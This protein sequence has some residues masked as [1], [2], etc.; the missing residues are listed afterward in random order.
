MC[1]QKLSFFPPLFFPARKAHFRGRYSI[2]S[3]YK[4]QLWPVQ[5]ALSMFSFDTSL[6]ATAAILTSCLNEL[7]DS[8]IYY[9]RQRG[10]QA[11]F[12]SWKNFCVFS[13]YIGQKAFL[14]CFCFD[15]VT[16]GD[17]K[18]YRTHHPVLLWSQGLFHFYRDIFAEAR[19][20]QVSCFVLTLQLISATHSWLHR[21]HCV[22]Q[23]W[24][25][26]GEIN[27]LQPYNG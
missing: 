25:D 23:A 17:A 3:P 21:C 27:L 4:R 2:C 22:S 9:C 19:R 12:F 7:S 10:A 14:G 8:Y 26:T 13:C 20:G 6:I 11:V 5:S 16:V 24:H 18:R 1:A 15:G